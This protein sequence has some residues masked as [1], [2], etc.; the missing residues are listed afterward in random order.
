MK[1][2][3]IQWITGCACFMAFISCSQTEEGVLLR[4]ENG[5]YFSA[6]IASPATRATEQAFEAGDNISVFAFTNDQ[7]FSTDAYAANVKYSYSDGAFRPVAD[8]GI[9][10]PANGGLSFWS[11]YPYC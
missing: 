4:N 7:D 3:I 8:A 2:D 9:D 5:V 10:Y 6:Q 1:K 11:I